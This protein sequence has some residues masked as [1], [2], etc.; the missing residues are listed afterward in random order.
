M[1]AGNPNNIVTFSTSI[2][3]NLNKAA[4]LP[5]KAA[6]IVNSP[7]SLVGGNVVVDPLKAPGGWNHINSYTAVVKGSAFVAGGGFGGVVV[8][9]QHN[10]PNKLGG[11]NGMSTVAK[12]S[13]VVNTAKAATAVAGGGT[14]TATSTASV[15]IVVPPQSCSL[16]VTVTKLYKKE[17]TLT[18]ANN[19]PADVVLSAFNLTWPAANGKLA[20]INLG[21]NVVYTT[22]INAPSAN[23]TAAQ[24]SNGSA[25]AK[26][27]LPTGTSSALKMTFQNNVDKTRPY[28]GSFTFGGCTLTLQ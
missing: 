24:L 22:D 28:T 26:R 13:T 9:D 20:Q 14:L 10:S 5:Y 6:L 25:D 21:S 12:D 2:S 3:D 11:P 15:N 7:T 1:V 18:I 4:N 16:A 23:L 19:G 8:P 17:F 27:T